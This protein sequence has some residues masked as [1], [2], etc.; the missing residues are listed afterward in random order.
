[1]LLLIPAPRWS[2]LLEEFFGYGDRSHRAGPTGVKRQMGDRF[3]Q[4]I[5]CYAVL[6]SYGE[7]GSKLVG[8][9]HRDESA[10]SNQ[11]AIPRGQSRTRPHIPKQHV[12]SELGQLG[13]D[14]AEHSLGRR[15]LHGSGGEGTCNELFHDFSPMLAQLKRELPQV[16]VLLVGD[17]LHPVDDLAVELFLDGDVGHGG[18]RRGAMPM[19]LACRARDNIT[20]SNDLDRPAPALHKT[21]AGRHDERLTQRMRVPIA[22]R[23]GLERYVGAARASGTGRLEKRVDAYGAGEIFGRSSRGG[24]RAVWFDVHLHSPVFD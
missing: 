16:A 9:V 15:G 6:E 2:V 7:V 18:G 12:V 4:L 19:L 13:G 1:M 11:A 21:A 20:R 3:D 24:L 8:A 5:L 14:V 10:D 17:F 23:A 22:P